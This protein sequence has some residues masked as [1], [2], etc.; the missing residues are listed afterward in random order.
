LDQFGTV[1]NSL[2]PEENPVWHYS[3]YTKYLGNA[4]RTDSAVDWPGHKEYPNER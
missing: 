3:K 4:C 1:W 2:E